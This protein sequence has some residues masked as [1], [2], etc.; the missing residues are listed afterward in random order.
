MKEDDEGIPFHTLLTTGTHRGDRIL[1]RKMRRWLCS[2]ILG[3]CTVSVRVASR[4]NG[5]GR[6]R[7][8]GEGQ[9]T[10]LGVEE[11]HSGRVVATHGCR[12]RSA[13]GRSDGQQGLGGAPG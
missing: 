7:R 9:G 1:R 3:S 4:G 2:S 11:W 8:T 13:R 6:W 10:A 12:R 5:Q